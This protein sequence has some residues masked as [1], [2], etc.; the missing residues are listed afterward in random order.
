MMLG[1]TSGEQSFVRAVH[2]TV[3][4]YHGI[5]E[6]IGLNRADVTYPLRISAVHAT[7]FRAVTGL[8]AC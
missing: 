7:R 3:H 5:K 6:T 2:S 8:L 4:V 1:A